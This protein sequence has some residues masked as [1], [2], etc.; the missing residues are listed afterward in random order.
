VNLDLQTV[1]TE[2]KA[3]SPESDSP[4]DRRHALPEP[5]RPGGPASEDPHCGSTRR[6]NF[7]AGAWYAIIA[8]AGLS[9]QPGSLDS[10]GQRYATDVGLSRETR[11]LS[12]SLTCEEESSLSTQAATMPVLRFPWKSSHGS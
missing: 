11:I 4:D 8:A 3:G 1:R 2:R 10:R 6:P 9:D 7:R 12:A 5:G